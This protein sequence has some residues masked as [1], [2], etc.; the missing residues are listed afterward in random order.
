MYDAKQATL[1]LI[2]STQSNQTKLSEGSLAPFISTYL[3]E[4]KS[5][6]QKVQRACS[7]L[8]VFCFV[9]DFVLLPR[10]QKQHVL[11]CCITAYCGKPKNHAWLSSFEALCTGGGNWY[12]Y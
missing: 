6:I 11:S 4:N 2:A 10:L 9:A 7:T 8:D 12:A 1:K 5:L 3:S